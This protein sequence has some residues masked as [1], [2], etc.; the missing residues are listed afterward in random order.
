MDD[1]EREVTKTRQLAKLV[2]GRLDAKADEKGRLGWQ[3]RP[4]NELLADA[5]EHMAELSTSASIMQALAKLDRSK[6]Y[7]DYRA[8]AIKEATDL[9]ASAMIVLDRLQAL[10]NEK[11][12]SD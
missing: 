4:F 2:M 9:A 10:D 11:P 5:R 8:A 3:S 1:R 12:T 6:Q 7:A